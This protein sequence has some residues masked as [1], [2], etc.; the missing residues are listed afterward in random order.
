[1]FKL[2]KEFIAAINEI[3]NTRGISRKRIK[4]MVGLAVRSAYNKI[5]GRTDNLVIEVDIDDKFVIQ[6]FLSRIVVDE[7]KN[8]EK[9]ISIEDANVEYP[10]AEIGDTIQT[11]VNLGK[12]D[13]SAV[14]YFRQKLL[15]LIKDEEREQV[16]QQFRDKIHDLFMVTV[17]H[18]DRKEVYVQLGRVEGIIPFHEQIPFEKHNNGSR[19]KVVL[20]EV[21]S[22]FRYPILV[23]SRSHPDLIRRLMENEIPEIREKNIEIVAV[24][25]DAGYRTKVSVRS[26][27]PDIDPVGS[28]IGSKGIRI[29]A[30][31][32]ELGEEKIDLIEYK[33][34][35]FEYIAECLSPVRPLSI[36]IFGDKRAVV[37]VPKEKTSLAIGK[38]YRNVTLAS[39]L[40][41]HQIEVISSDED[42]SAP[43]PERRPPSR[44]KNEAKR[45]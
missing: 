37:Q 33:E 29:T 32:N 22:N 25:R 20:T 35:I 3:E 31:S 34:D 28:C 21:R 15:T 23:F 36:E 7:P 4:E 2:D 14:H 8:Q 1:M 5:N 30:I 26:L 44:R 19:I 40:T 16:Y 17:T 12:L 6:A 18:V 42:P 38:K 45:T 41:R 9:E 11:E 43:R 24:A 27:V 10:E 13:M 39:K